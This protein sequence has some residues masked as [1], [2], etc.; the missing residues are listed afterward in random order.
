M[1]AVEASRVEEFTKIQDKNEELKCKL[2]DSQ[3]GLQ[4]LAND[5]TAITA[6]VSILEARARAAEESVAHE[7]FVRDAVIQEVVVWAMDNFK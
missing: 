5:P 6:K 4:A 3:A 1:E 7:E 2:R